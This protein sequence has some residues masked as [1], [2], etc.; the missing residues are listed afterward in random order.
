VNDLEQIFTLPPYG[1]ARA[2]KQQLLMTNLKQ[3]IA[4]H[5]DKCQPY[6]NILNALDSH[7]YDSIESLPYLPVSLFKQFALKSI[8]DTDVIKTLTSSGTTSQSVSRIFL[9]KQT[10]RYQTKALSLI[11]QDFIGKKRLPMLIIDSNQVIKDR[12]LFSA[13]GAGILGLANF[14]RDHLYVLDENMR[15]D[16]PALEAFLK[17]HE[18]ETILMFGF[19]FMIWQHFYRELKKLERSI[20]L[21]QG[22]L[23]HSGG[24]KKLMDQA[25][26][27]H[28]FKQTFKELCGLE[29]IHNFYGMVEQV[30][31]IFMEC[32]EGHFHTPIY[33]DIVVRDHRDWSALGFRQNGVIE[34]V[35]ILPHS[36]PG[37]ILLTED[38]GEILGEDDCPCGRKG[39]YFALSGRIPQAEVRGCSDTYEV[40][41]PD[42]AV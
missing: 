32:Q 36:Y 21:S 24:W 40:K 10:S 8:D 15:L 13:R 41:E 5:S 33:A 26:D 1:L 38:M 31:S 37:H 12:R 16:L 23:I 19:T 39:R 9:D 11:V 42:H 27:N 30:G 35:S 17:K 6:R 20:D 18:G 7:D 29:K 2:D 28:V 4:L 22:I 3:L 34:L 14:G 25:V